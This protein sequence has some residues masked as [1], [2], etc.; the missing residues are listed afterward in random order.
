MWGLSCPTRVWTLVP[1]SGRRSLNPWTASLLWGCRWLHLGPTQVIQADVPLS[2]PWTKVYLQRPFFHVWEQASKTQDLDIFWSPSLS[3]MLL[4]LRMNLV[5]LQ[6]RQVPPP[7][8][9]PLE[10]CK[11]GLL[12]SAVQQSALFHMCMYIC[13]RE[14]VCKN[15]S[16][17]FL[18]WFITGYWM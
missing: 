15:I 14:Y 17:S 6:P 3:I 1:C 2:R 9:N 12:I 11:V 16:Y 13:V 4:V 10:S 7:T 8:A 5:S 18:L